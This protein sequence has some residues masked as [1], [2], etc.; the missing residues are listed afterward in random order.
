M[1]ENHEFSMMDRWG[2]GVWFR[3]GAR[4][5]DEH[6]EVLGIILMRRMNAPRAPPRSD[7]AFSD[8]AGR[9]PR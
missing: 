5:V 4:L 6:P 8:R 1:G 7:G 9:V 2:A 3:R